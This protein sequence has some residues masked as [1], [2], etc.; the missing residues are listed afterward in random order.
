[1]LCSS[2]SSGRLSIIIS[3]K[4]VNALPSAEGSSRNL[5]SIAGTCTMANCLSLFF[6]FSLISLLSS[7]TAMFS[8]LL[9]SWGKGLLP[10]TARG[11]STGNRT[12]LKYL[13]RYSFCF[14]SISSVE[15]KRMPLR[16]RAGRMERCRQE[17][18]RSIK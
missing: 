12:F 5:G 16:S 2:N 10:S 8:D 17:Y 13:S 15:R 18:C 11:V 6:S 9:A 7:R 3:S 1:M 14:S 4:R